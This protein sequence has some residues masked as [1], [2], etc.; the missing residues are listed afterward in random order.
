MKKNY[1]NTLRVRTPYKSINPAF[2]AVEL[3][4]D[5]EHKA[6]HICGANWDQEAGKLQ[7]FRL[8]PTRLCYGVG[9]ARI[10]LS[11]YVAYENDSPIRWEKPQ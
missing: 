11:K 1:R 9:G 6:Y 5:D 4:Y 8:E 3:H 10:A 7:Y 2:D